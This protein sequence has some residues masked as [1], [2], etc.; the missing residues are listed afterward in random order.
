MITANLMGMKGFGMKHIG[1]TCRAG[2][3]AALALIVPAQQAQSHPHLYIDAGLKLDI[4]NGQIAGIEVSW[5]Y[6]EFYTL[7]VLE[8]GDFDPDFDGIVTAEDKARM[9]GWDM[10]WVE[11]FEGDLFV[12]APDGTKVKLGPPEPLTTNVINRRIITRHIRRPLTP[13]P[14][15]GAV[16]Q[17]AD[18][19]YYVAYTMDSGVVV[20]AGC[21]AEISRP[22]IDDTY[23]ERQK[24]MAKLGKNAQNVPQLG[25]YFADKIT[26]TCQADS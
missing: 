9:H 8:Q 3:I 23:R 11:G 15:D 18:P 5:T 24:E 4:V 25:S 17:V 12:L 2:A 26:L 22:T 19:S 21:R 1:L 20:E 6:D 16:L 7:M 10:N 14:A 13:L